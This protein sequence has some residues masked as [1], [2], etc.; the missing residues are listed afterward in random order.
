MATRIANK[1][2]HN[3]VETRQPF[4][5]SNLKGVVEDG[6][7]AVYSYFTPVLFY[8]GEKWVRNSTKYS[9]TTSK[10]LTQACRLLEWTHHVPEQFF[11]QR[12]QETKDGLLTH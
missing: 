4:Q 8:D 7:Y 11:N 5:G 6:V 10:Q 12:L 3:F 1:W 2:C 9:A